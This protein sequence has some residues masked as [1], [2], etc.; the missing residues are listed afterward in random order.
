MGHAVNIVAKTFEALA[1]CST[2]ILPAAAQMSADGD[3]KDSATRAEVAE[4]FYKCH[5]LFKFLQ[6]I[7]SEKIR[8]ATVKEKSD[9]QL[10]LRYNKLADEFFYL[11]DNIQKGPD[12]ASEPLP[13]NKKDKIKSTFQQKIDASVDE[14]FVMASLAQCGPYLKYTG[15][16]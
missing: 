8:R 6:E 7:A 16:Q 9:V 2:I 3:F 13:N 14:K 5:T 4:Q 11:S 12:G 1:I 10:A 15:N